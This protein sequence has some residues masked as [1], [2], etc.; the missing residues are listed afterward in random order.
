M[1][2]KNFTLLGFR[3]CINKTSKRISEQYS[4][5]LCKERGD[6]LL[7]IYTKKD[8][9]RNTVTIELKPKYGD[10]SSYTIESATMAK[11]E[12]KFITEFNLDLRDLP[13]YLKRYEQY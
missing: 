13:L 12:E 9:N 11:I 4:R 7:R 10:L 3:S 1:T 5:Y 8:E 6:Y 2:V